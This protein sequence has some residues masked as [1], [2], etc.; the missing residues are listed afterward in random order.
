MDSM[1]DNIREYTFQLKNGRIQK[2]YRGIMTFM[3]EL[4]TYLESKR[5]DYTVSALYF[6][7]MDMTYFAFTPPELK[8]LRL[9]IAV[10][11]LH[12]ENRFEVWLAAGNRQI[13]SEYVEVFRRKNIGEYILSEIRP[14]VDSIIYSSIVERPDFD[15]P[16]E[17]KR[18]IELKTARFANDVVLLLK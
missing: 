1:N 10:V 6:G 4:M 8:D 12:E 18:Q 9:K 14:G 16:D 2:A 17:L 7:Y 13:Q 5:P 11:Y 15:N 3:T